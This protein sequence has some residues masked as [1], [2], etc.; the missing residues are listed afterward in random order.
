MRIAI[1]GTGGAGGYF[2]GKLATAG[3]EVTFIARGK[4]LESTWFISWSVG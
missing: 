3:E 4:H 1:Y 2:G